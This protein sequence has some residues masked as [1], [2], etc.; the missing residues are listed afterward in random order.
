MKDETLKEDE[1]IERV[2][3]QTEQLWQT[4]Q[5]AKKSNL[6]IQVG[7][8]NFCTKP[9]INISKELFIQSGN[10]NQYLNA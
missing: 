3:T 10:E 2:K 5:E 4:I 8:H 9:E 1:L 6:N 7:F